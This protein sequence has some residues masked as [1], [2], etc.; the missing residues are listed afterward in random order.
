MSKILSVWKRAPHG[1][2]TK[3][4][5]YS[6]CKALEP[7]NIRSNPPKI[8][9]DSD[10]A[11]GIVN[12]VET[13]HVNPNGVLLGQ[14]FE[15][16]NFWSEVGKSIPDGSFALFR[17]DPDFIEVIS[18]PAGSRSI[19]YY[20]DESQLIAATSQRAIIMYLGSFEFNEETIPWMLSTGTLGPYLSW[21][22][23]IHLLPP[24]T[25][26]IL[27][28]VKWISSIDTN[29]IRFG[30]QPVSE[31]EGKKKVSNAIDQV[32]E[33]LKLDFTKW[34]LTLS[35][36]KDSRGI[37]LALLAKHHTARKIKTYTYGHESSEQVKGSDGFI[38][39]QLADK[40][41]IS[42]EFF[43]AY[44]ISERYS[45]EDI[46]ER[47]LKIGEGR[48]DHI[49]AYVDGFEFWKHLFE[50]KVSGIIRGDIGFGFPLP[51][52]FKTEKEARYFG[53]FYLLK[54]YANLAHLE[55][56]YKQKFPKEFRPM[57][58]ESMNVYHDRLYAIFRTPIVLAALSDFKLSYVE[59]CSPLLSKKI[60]K[61]VR[62]LPEKF[63]LASP[64]WSN[65]VEALEN[66]IPYSNDTS[67]DQYLNEI[68]K[69][70]FMTHLINKISDSPYLSQELKMLI[71]QQKKPLN[72][73]KSI[74]ISWVRKY[75]IKYFLS[76]V[77]RFQL[78]RLLGGN[79]KKAVL[80]KE[81]LVSRLFIVTEMQ[82]LLNIESKLLQKEK[83][84][85]QKSKADF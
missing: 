43:T 27:D 77:Q 24:N 5:F 70:S 82:R 46:C 40:Y 60:L 21:D 52:Q 84:R 15:D 79:R 14:L 41:K 2:K 33:K 85:Q 47:I 16:N 51:I 76:P 44:S 20:L 74:L 61:E 67:Y 56:I 13:I 34:S 39:R 49:G 30:Y 12:P 63:R 54:E 72:T 36:G 8:N 38:A 3:D 35:G 7:D 45:L 26:L 71:P 78:W 25:T 73:P 80:S 57:N 81:K 64:I 6:I 19:W 75:R 48:V 4:K 66:E 29:Q 69:E 83:T 37:L 31:E 9:I 42:N 17:N 11:Y 65:Y 55:Q 10:W 62:M 22:K 68:G 58:G 18:D 50:N 1:S 23:R 28:K 53:N 59:V 32:F